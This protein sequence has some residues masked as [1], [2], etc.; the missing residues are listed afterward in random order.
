[1]V[2][3]FE[4][5]LHD[6]T[7]AKA[8]VELLNSYACDFFGGNEPLSDY[9]RTNLICE[10]RKLPSAHVFVA[11]DVGKSEEYVGLAICF[12]GFSTFACKP[13]INVHDFYVRPEFR[14]QGISSNLIFAIGKRS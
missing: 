3:C 10:L 6:E 2:Q 4:A 14:R 5:D 11:K 13:L 7:M 9:S 1:M 8:I 12:E